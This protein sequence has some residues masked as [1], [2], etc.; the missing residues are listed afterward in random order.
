M[1]VAG[2]RKWRQRHFACISCSI[3][4]QLS[5][6]CNMLCISNKHHST[7]FCRTFSLMQNIIFKAISIKNP[8]YI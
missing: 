5:L 4:P 6:H 7:A 1:G 3:D 2:S 8:D